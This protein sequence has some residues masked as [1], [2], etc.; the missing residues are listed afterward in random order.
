MEL[1][2][3]NTI[4]I[5][6][7][8]IINPLQYLI[9]T[10]SAPIFW[11][12]ANIYRG[13]DIPVSNGAL[14]ASS[15]IDLFSKSTFLNSAPNGLIYSTVESALQ[16]NSTNIIPTV[17]TSFNG[18]SSYTIGCIFANPARYPGNS[19]D[20]TPI[21]RFNGSLDPTYK[22]RVGLYQ[23]VLFMRI[24]D[25]TLQYLTVIMVLILI[26]LLLSHLMQ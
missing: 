5:H 16:Y 26:Q 3:S 15:I 22:Y 12:R 14:N 20:L 24:M 17:L 7:S 6:P 23:V 10:G 1:L 2:N 8:Q 13:K 9:M 18:A 25:L 19:M 11:F 4:K 21:V